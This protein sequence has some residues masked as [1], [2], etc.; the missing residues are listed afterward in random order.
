MSLSCPPKRTKCSHMIT[1][2]RQQS[3]PCLGHAA[4]ITT[5]E[6]NS[7]FLRASSWHDEEIADAKS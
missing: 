2:N 3:A 5:A 1:E 4:I 7:R 6:S